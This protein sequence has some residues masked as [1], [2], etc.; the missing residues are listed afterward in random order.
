MT[1]ENGVYTY[2][3][4][5]DIFLRNVHFSMDTEKQWAAAI[6]ACINLNR[7]KR[8]QRKKRSFWMK[9]W[10]DRRDDLGFYNTL[11][12]EFRTEDT[13]EY[14]TSISPYL[15][16]LLCEFNAFMFVRHFVFLKAIQPINTFWRPN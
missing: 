5:S 14:Y 3:L 15:D 16:K 10:L 12:Q 4:K 7:K 8:K 1:L 2:H 11:M 6:V 13:E 9:P